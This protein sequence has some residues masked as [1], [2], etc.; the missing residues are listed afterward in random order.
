MVDR[1]EN[2]HFIGKVPV[3]ALLGLVCPL[4]NS[5]GLS[6]IKAVL[7][8]FQL[9][10]PEVFCPSPELRLFTPLDQILGDK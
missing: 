8:K 3:K 6:A 2:G 1:E 5:V 7:F 10:S 9:H 4:G